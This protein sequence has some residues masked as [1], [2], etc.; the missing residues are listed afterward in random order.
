MASN[1]NPISAG[2]GY[3]LNPAV[4]PPAYCITVTVQGLL[5]S[6]TLSVFIIVAF[7]QLAPPLPKIP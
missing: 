1:V 5:D 3:S 7:V 6:L 2:M 4:F